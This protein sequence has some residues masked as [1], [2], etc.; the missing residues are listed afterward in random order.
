M[1]HQPV[2]SMCWNSPSETMEDEIRARRLTTATP[3]ILEIRFEMIM[4]FL[5]R[6]HSTLLITS[7]SK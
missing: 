5:M 1:N 7:S 6:K 3:I 4:A 2:R